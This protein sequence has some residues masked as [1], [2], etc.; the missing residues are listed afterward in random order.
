MPLKMTIL[1]VKKRGQIDTFFNN[2]QIDNILAYY[3]NLDTLFPTA[4]TLQFLLY[5][6]NYEEQTVPYWIPFFQSPGGDGLVAANIRT[7]FFLVYLFW[8]SL[9]LFWRNNPIA[10]VN[11][12]LTSK[13]IAYGRPI[14]IASRHCVLCRGQD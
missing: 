11:I 7:N 3:S 2:S 5:G 14:C 10:I 6:I 13:K 9:S 8:F 4:R 12:L 1:Q